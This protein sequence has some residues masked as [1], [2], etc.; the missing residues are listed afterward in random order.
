MSPQGMSPY[1]SKFKG[2]CVWGW[3]GGVGV[4]MCVGGGRC[5]CVGGWVYFPQNSLEPAKEIAFLF[6]M[7]TLMMFHFHFFVSQCE[8]TPPPPVGLCPMHDDGGDDYREGD[9]DGYTMMAI[10]DVAN[11]KCPLLIIGN[12]NCPCVHLGITVLFY[13]QKLAKVF[14]RVKI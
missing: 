2:V 8:F 3:G 7:A 5:V 13:P 4:C 9:D 1:G 11:S 14:L 10:G 12:V 6:Y